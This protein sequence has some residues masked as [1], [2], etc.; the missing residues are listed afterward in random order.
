MVAIRDVPI[1]RLSLRKPFNRESP[2]SDPQLKT[3]TFHTK[4]VIVSVEHIVHT[5][6]RVLSTSK[7][8]VLKFI[9]YLIHM[10]SQDLSPKVQQE[11]L[12]A[13]KKDPNEFEKIYNYYYER[14]L[15]YL[16]KR[17]NSAEAAY[18]ITA[19]TFMKAFES[20]HKFY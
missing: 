6:L 13:F 11:I 19:D 16:L 10:N 1:K 20:F 15:K 7:Y 12:E 17:T 8:S 14:I 3:A 5:K 18:D 4:V 9:T 2:F